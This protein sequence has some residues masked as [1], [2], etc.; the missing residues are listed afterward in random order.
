M[1][2]CVVVTFTF[3]VRVF[4][5][6]KLTHNNLSLDSFSLFPHRSFVS[7]NAT[8]SCSALSQPSVFYI[9]KKVLNLK[10]KSYLTSHHHHH[11]HQSLVSKVKLKH[12]FLEDARSSHI[13]LNC[14]PLYVTLYP[15]KYATFDPV[16]GIYTALNQRKPHRGKVDQPAADWAG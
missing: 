7:V 5:L 2:V 13:L 4:V 6:I 3:S 9:V 1:V 11:S 12:D 16:R 10:N 8:F 15:K 14:L